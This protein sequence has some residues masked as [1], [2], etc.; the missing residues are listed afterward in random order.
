VVTALV[1]EIATLRDN[2]YYALLIAGH[3]E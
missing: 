1:A 2:L 3:T